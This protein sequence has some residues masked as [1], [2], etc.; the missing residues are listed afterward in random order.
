MRGRPAGVSP[1]VSAVAERLAERIRSGDYLGSDLPSEAALAAEH[2][3]SYLTARRAVARLVAEGLLVRERNGRLSLAP[4]PE[5]R[6]LMLGWVVPTWASFDVLRWHRALGEAATRRDAVLRPLQAS[7]WGDPALVAMARRADGLVVYPGEW[8]PP[9]DALVA[10]VRMVVV[11]RASGRDDVPGLVANP[12]QSVDEL[13]HALAGWG[14]RRIAWVGEVAGSLV[15]PVRRARWLA[16]GGT[17]EYAPER[18]ALAAALRA[19]ACDAVIAG[20]LEHALLVLRA[21]RDAGVRV[22]EDVAVAVANDE[23]L[24]ESLVPSLCA[25]ATPDLVAWLVAALAW[26]ADRASPW[27]PPVITPAIARRETA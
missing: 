1:K 2:Q 23:G 10:A 16:C 9:P 25:P 3:V 18:A 14:R 5:A 17:I 21:A 24:G 13:Y 7:G 4:S 11:D 20:T 26:I 12:P 27:T 19:R 8:G 22:P 6:P 15:M